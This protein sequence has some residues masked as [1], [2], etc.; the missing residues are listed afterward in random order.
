VMACQNASGLDE[1][2]RGPIHRLWITGEGA[3]GRTLPVWQREREYSSS[4]SSQR[5]GTASSRSAMNTARCPRADHRHGIDQARRELLGP[6]P[7]EQ[8]RH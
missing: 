6:G 5:P 1:V 3:L 8:W 4:I 7:A 2:A